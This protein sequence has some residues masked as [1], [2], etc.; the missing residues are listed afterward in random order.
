MYPSHDDRTLEKKIGLISRMSKKTHFRTGPLLL[1]ERS[2][3]NEVNFLTSSE[4]AEIL[5]VS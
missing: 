1:P 2:T 4:W 3:E 5:Q